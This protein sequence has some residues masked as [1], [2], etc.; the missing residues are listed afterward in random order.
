M[1]QNV[2]QIYPNYLLH[3]FGV[4]GLYYDSYDAPSDTLF[5]YPVIPDLDPTASERMSGN[6]IFRDKN[7]VWQVRSAGPLLDNIWAGGNVKH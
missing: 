5:V 6:D 7:I 4:K 1:D 2:F 3:I